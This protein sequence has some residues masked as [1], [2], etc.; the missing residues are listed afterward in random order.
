MN[1]KK[2]LVGVAAG[3]M[4]AAMGVTAFAEPVYYSDDSYDWEADGIDT[5]V[6]KMATLV[7]E[8]VADAEISSFTYDLTCG[9]DVNFNEYSYVIFY[10]TVDGESTA[11]KVQGIGASTP[12]AEYASDEWTNGFTITGATLTLDAPIAAGSTYKVEAFTQSW[13]GAANEVYDV[14][15]ATGASDSAEDDGSADTAD[16]APVAY[17]A[18]VVAVAGVAMVASKKARA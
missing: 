4:V 7:D 12:F 2:V 3:A 17:L 11:Y 15:I 5:S 16:V 8:T 1:F 14:T 10:V 9:A 13:S 18:A 6:I